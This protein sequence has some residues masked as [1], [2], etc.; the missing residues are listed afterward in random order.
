YTMLRDSASKAP[1]VPRS[2]L[3]SCFASYQNA[4]AGYRE[5]HSYFPI[6]GGSHSGS[7]PSVQLAQA[8]SGN[9]NNQGHD[10]STNRI[11]LDADP[12]ILTLCPTKISIPL[13]LPAARVR[14][15]SL[16]FHKAARF[17]P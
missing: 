16:I 10:A 17:P 14:H 7:S 5:K 1:L 12:G 9:D 8:D 13:S 11:K 4:A 6:P 15:H 3:H 2:A